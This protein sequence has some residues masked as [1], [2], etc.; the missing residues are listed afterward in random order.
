MALV[1]SLPVKV[2]DQT[3]QFHQKYIGNLP[4]LLFLHILDNFDDC[5]WNKALFRV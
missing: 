5:M 4:I 2:E 1:S 3:I